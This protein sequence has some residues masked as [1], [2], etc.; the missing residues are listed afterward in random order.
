MRQNNV[1]RPLGLFHTS[2]KNRE[3]SPSGV[4][5]CISNKLKYGTIKH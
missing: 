1:L 3:F 2:R 5:E 4:F